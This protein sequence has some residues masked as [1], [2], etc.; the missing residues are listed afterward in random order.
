MALWKRKKEKRKTVFDAM[1]GTA[2][3][4]PSFCLSPTFFSFMSTKLETQNLEASN[5]T[6]TVQV[7]SNLYLILTHFSCPINLEAQT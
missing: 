6:H 7:F 3:F 4:Q 1:D 5:R 2:A